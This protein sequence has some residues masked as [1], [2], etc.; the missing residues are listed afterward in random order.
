M[1]NEHPKRNVLGCYLIHGTL[2]VKKKKNGLTCVLPMPFCLPARPCQPGR[3]SHLPMVLVHIESVRKKNEIKYFQLKCN[4]I[5]E[6]N[7]V[8]FFAGEKFGGKSWGEKS[9]KYYEKSYKI[10]NKK[11]GKN[12][13]R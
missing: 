8:N 1:I 2:N 13:H 10:V 9:A 11:L 4:I 7:F 5:W 3:L 6:I 12:F